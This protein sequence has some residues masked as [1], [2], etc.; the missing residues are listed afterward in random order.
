MDNCTG[1]ILL[2][3]HALWPLDDGQLHIIT[4]SEQEEEPHLG[5]DTACKTLLRVNR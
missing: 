5:Q 3:L 4:A 2:R 1:L